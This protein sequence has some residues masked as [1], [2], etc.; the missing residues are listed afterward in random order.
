MIKQLILL[1]NL[2]SVVGLNFMMDEN[3]SIEVNAPKHAEAGSEFIVEMTI[4]KGALDGF[5]KLQQSL[6]EGLSAAKKETSNATFSFKEQKVKCIWMA[7]PE[8][9][10]FKVSY[11]VQ[12]DEAASGMYEIEGAFSFIENNEK[13]SVNIPRIQ[14]QVGD[15]IEPVLADTPPEE[16]K[17]VTPKATPK[18]EMENG[19]L[20]TRTISP[21]KGKQE[22]F[23]VEI[24]ITANKDGF[25]KM[26]EY[27]PSGFTASEIES[28]EGLFSFKN[29]TV[30]IIWMTLPNQG[31]FI[32]AYKLVANEAV[33]G[34]Q[35]INGT[36]SYIEENLTK[37]FALTPSNIFIE[38]E[39]GEVAMIIIDDEGGEFEETPEE[40][41]EIAV[42]EEFTIP[43][44][45]A[46]DEVKSFA[47]E[48]VDVPDPEPVAEAVKKITNTPAPE[49]DVRYK[50]QVAAGH[51]SVPG[52]YF[53]KKYQLKDKISIENHEGWIKYTIGSFPVYKQ[54]RD[55]RNKV[56][57]GNSI[58][59][60][61][62]T[63]Y[64][65]GN[66]I[67]VQEALMIT[68]QKWYN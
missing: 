67:T 39:D 6:P 49:T 14:V 18:R 55:H 24:K 5:A 52:D 48:P 61:F 33:T 2:I 34:N 23:K 38:Q 10:S 37:K 51:K 65:R 26:E 28:M 21:V 15:V 58:N 43:T 4:N 11:V 42:K 46:D 63:A 17:I 64:N 20:C 40:A 44:P 36:F 53:S 32:V 62:V 22:E 66:R 35:K 8:S 13:K 9:T 68:N 57:S 60:A 25:A 7:L 27:I 56:W 45:E 31:E 59:D 19:V 30:K 50:V 12:V 3:V 1:F 47:S 54:G 41:P 16:E 29:Q